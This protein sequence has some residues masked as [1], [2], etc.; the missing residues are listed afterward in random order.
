M[1]DENGNIIT[2][3]ARHTLSDDPHREAHLKIKKKYKSE[4]GIYRDF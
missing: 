1:R 2:G 4:L 3:L